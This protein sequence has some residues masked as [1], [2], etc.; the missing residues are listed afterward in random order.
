MKF[1]E[2]KESSSSF[3][4]YGKSTRASQ[5]RGHNF[6]W[7]A[8]KHSFKKFIQIF[9]KNHN[10]CGINGILCSIWKLLFSFISLSAITFIIYLKIKCNWISSAIKM[11][12]RAKSNL[13]TSKCN[14]KTKPS[15]NLHRFKWNLAKTG[16]AITMNP[17]L[18][19]HV[20]H[21]LMNLFLGCP[22]CCKTRCQINS[23]Q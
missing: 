16:V 4:I 18:K 19:V 6:N 12:E 23:I 20:K 8:S 11:Y 3:S 1:T 14:S 2:V 5:I 22:I 21:W 7:V 15:W 13:S 9:V 10:S 17:Y